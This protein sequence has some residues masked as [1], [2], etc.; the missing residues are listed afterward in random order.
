[1]PRAVMSRSRILNV[2]FAS[3]LFLPLPS[4]SFLFLPLPSSSFLFLPLPSSS[5]LFLPLPSS[6]FLFLP[7]PSSSFLL[8]FGTPR[9]TS[10]HRL[11]VVLIFCCDAGL[12]HSHR[13]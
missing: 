6:S 11:V 13:D 1:M 2:G 9:T 8:T 7:L 12:L 3:F 10:R 4:S 5:F